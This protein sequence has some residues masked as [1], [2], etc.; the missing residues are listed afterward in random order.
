MIGE[1]SLWIRNL[2]SVSGEEKVTK[3]LSYPNDLEKRRAR[4]EA[5][6]IASTKLSR[7]IKTRNKQKGT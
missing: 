4:D 3:G 1:A 2:F 7:V 6:F 5:I